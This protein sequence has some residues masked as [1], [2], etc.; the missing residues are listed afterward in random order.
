M[1][2]NNS[3]DL[4]V[5]Q[6][7]KEWREAFQAHIKSLQETISQRDKELT[8]EKLKFEKLKE[9]FEYN[10]KLLYERDE[11]LEKYDSVIGQVKET[12]HSKTAQISELYAQLDEMKLKLDN[13]QKAKE[14]MQKYY[15]KV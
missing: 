13:E 8:Q 9:D 3:L 6:K 7:E 2:T 10:L 5:F 15:Q 14:E 1:S 4:V 11:E 12:D